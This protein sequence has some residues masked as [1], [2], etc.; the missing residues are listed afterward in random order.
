MQSSLIIYSNRPIFDHIINNIYLG[1]IEAI[2]DSVCMEDIDIIINASNSRYVEDPSKKYYHFDIHDTPSYKIYDD[3]DRFD[4]IM[5]QIKPNQKVL[6]HCMSGVSRSVTLVLYYLMQYHHMT[7]KDAYEYV[8]SRREQYTIPNR[9][10]FRQLRRL[11]KDIHGCNSLSMSD[12][13][14]IT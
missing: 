11:E 6:I 2:H 13:D 7:L 12:Y 3:I 5:E 9:G 10:F 14:N 4:A 1:D 8:T